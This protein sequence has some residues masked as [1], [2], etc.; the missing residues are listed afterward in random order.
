MWSRRR[1]RPVALV[2]AAAA[3]AWSAGLWLHAPPAGAAAGSRPALLLD[4]QTQWVTPASAGAPTTF[5][6]VLSAPNAPAGAQVAVTLYSR[7][8]SRDHFEQVVQRGP[9]STPLSD[10]SPVPLAQLPADPHTPGGVDLN[11]QVT[12]APSTGGQALGLACSG[13]AVTGT[14]TG[15][16]PVRV[17]LLDAAGNVLQRLTTFL[18]Y[19]ARVS[20]TPL[21]F[22]WVVPVS[23][24]VSV[25]AGATNPRTALEPLSRSEVGALA[26]LVRLLHAAPSVP[27]TID[28]SPETLQ[29][30]AASGPTG[31]AAVTTVAAMSADQSVDEV[32]SAPYVP[33]D[34]ASLSGAGEATEITAQMAA[35]ATVLHK[36]GVQTSPT[37]PWLALPPVGNDIG[38]GLS[39]VGASQVVVQD[40]SLAPTPTAPPVTWAST[41]RLALGA[42]SVEAAQTDSFLDGQFRHAGSDPAL[43]ATQMLADLAMVHFERPYTRHARG[44]IAVPPPGWTPDATFVRTLLAGLDGN[45]VVTPVTLDKFFST[46]APAGTRTLQ[47]N[48]AGPSLSR[49]LARS[50][51]K[52]RIRLTQFEQAV[53][54]K[55]GKPAVLGQ[56]DHLL[57]A[58][59]FD[60]LSTRGHAGAVAVFEHAL[61]HQLGQ[62][63]FIATEKAFTLTA[64]TGVIPITV[65]SHAPYTV[66]GTLTVSGA[67]FTFPPGNR[68]E[69]SH[70]MV[71][72]HPANTL[73]VSVLARSSGDLPLDVA[74]TS[75]TGL[76]IAQEQLTVR[77]T[78]TSVVGVLLTGLALAVLLTWWAR[79]WRARRRRRRRPPTHPA[80][81]SERTAA[82]VP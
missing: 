50:L 32:P 43:A 28:A 38:P 72:D 52:A 26:Q 56:L 11:L 5:Q 23:A 35:G 78:A 33:V 17:A 15:V 37:L 73:R 62:V 79:T 76:V 65:V 34:L 8:D 51:S 63:S 41:F 20:A 53:Q 81:Q 46:V 7:L 58:A 49:S 40:S 59:E 22:A 14:C 19:S 2:F 71:L 70:P 4:G 64:R 10:A 54:G 45:P 1:A 80:D 75:P 9:R 68:T 74:F 67:R 69:T 44:M 13:T 25:V 66:T 39:R 47:A 60:R 77:S 36:L 18:T 57:L 55:D 12:T 48:G 21:N 29:A 42:R 61:S 16:Y 82:G 24:P 3:L 27:V 6:L 30:L 31:R